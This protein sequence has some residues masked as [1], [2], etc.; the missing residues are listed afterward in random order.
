MVHF[1][2]AMS[3]LLLSTKVV[4][5]DPIVVKVRAPNTE[6]NVC[7]HSIVSF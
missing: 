6:R 2:V 5:L 7:I 4:A 1:T 3:A